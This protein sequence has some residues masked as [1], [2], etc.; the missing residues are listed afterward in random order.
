MRASIFLIC[1]FASTLVMGQDSLN[2]VVSRIKSNAVSAIAYK[3]TRALGLFVEQWKGSGVFYTTA[4]GTLIKQQI[5]PEPEIMG[6]IGN[7]LYYYKA[8]GE[9]RYQTEMDDS[10]AMVLPVIAFKGLMNGDLKYLRQ[11]Y[12]VDFTAKKQ[13]WTLLLTAQYFE[14]EEGEQATTV[15][16]QGFS[17]KLAHKLEI[18]TADGDKSEFNLS[19]VKQTEEIKADITRLSKLLKGN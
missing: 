9:K 10:D 6:V 3:E 11:Y 4:Q 17:G 13:Q 16:M 7:Q 2:S 14:P 8:E 1:Y 19:P 15:T 5:Q 12:D 18:H